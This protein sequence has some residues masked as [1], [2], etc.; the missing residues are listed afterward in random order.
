MF[1]LAVNK[2]KL[3]TAVMEDI[4]ADVRPNDKKA[5]VM[6]K[7]IAGKSKSKITQFK[8]KTD[9]IKVHLTLQQSKRGN[10]LKML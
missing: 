9:L 8:N 4:N 6:K 10:F 2:G 3:P 7:V 5:V 1:I